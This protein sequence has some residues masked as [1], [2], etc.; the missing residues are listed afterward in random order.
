[1]YL[2]HVQT[3]SQHLQ[4]DTLVDSAKHLENQQSS[5]FTEII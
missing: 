3:I 1:M 5:T 2:I 4:A